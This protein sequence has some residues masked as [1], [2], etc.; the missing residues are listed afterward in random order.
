VRTGIELPALLIE[1]AR[2]V[3]TF[4]TTA[5]NLRDNNHQKEKVAIADALNKLGSLKLGS[6]NHLDWNPH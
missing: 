6:L 2:R 3:E 5:N 4:P 1:F